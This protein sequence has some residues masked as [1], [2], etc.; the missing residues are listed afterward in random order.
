MQT[1]SVTKTDEEI[2]GEALVRKDAFGVLV[3][4][5]QARLSRYVRRLGVNRKEDTEDILQNV[6]LK[7][8]R[9]LNGFDR[10]LKFSTWIYRIAHNEAMSFFRSRSVRPEGYVIED[11]E[12]LLEGLR[13][14]LDLARTAEQSLD[15]AR[16]THALAAL[17][18]KYRDAI[19]LRYFEE[20]EYAE[21]S[22]ILQIPVGTVA[23][24][25][26]RAKKRLQKLLPNET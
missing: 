21:M 15:A 2:V 18:P 14:S 17:E 13:S 8:Y 26:S 12:T 3:E 6:F 1:P 11:G 16:L 7:T 10:D 25:L 5:Y 20:R 24:L 23:T 22:D 4:R 9:N 19:V